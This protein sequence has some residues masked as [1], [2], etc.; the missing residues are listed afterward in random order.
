MATRWWVGL[1]LGFAKWREALCA[2]LKLSSRH[3]T[4]RRRWYVLFAKEIDRRRALVE[5]VYGP[6]G[7]SRA[8]F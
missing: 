3:S 1:L 4:H 2:V 7:P 6:G 8:A 5:P